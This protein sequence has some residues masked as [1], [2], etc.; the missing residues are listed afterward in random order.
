MEDRFRSIATEF[1][2]SHP[3]RSA[4]HNRRCLTG[5]VGPFGAANSGLPGM[6]GRSDRAFCFAP[7]SV[8][9]WLGTPGSPTFCRRTAS[10][11]SVEPER[12]QISDAGSRLL[13]Q[14]AEGL[15]PIAGNKALIRILK[16]PAPSAFFGL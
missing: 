4:P 3:F 5:P 15:N 14:R 10:P 9:G 12:R 1:G 13:E 6:F 2:L 8:T 11:I 7:S 16:T